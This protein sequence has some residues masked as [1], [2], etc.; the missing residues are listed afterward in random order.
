MM[1]T[2]NH[3]IAE[4]REHEELVNSWLAYY[5]IL[6]DSGNITG[7]TDIANPHLWAIDRL[8]DIGRL[9][10]EL[11]WQLILEILD[12]TVSDLQRVSLA[13][14]PLEDLLNRYGNDFIDRVEAVAGQNE[15]FREL[16]PGIWRNTI[17]AEVWDRIQR[18][19]S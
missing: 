4:F 3:D 18:L 19:C 7:Q 11:C 6:E 5:R 16:L 13:A 15:K 9:Q 12:R 10:P 14:G 8:D 2:D 1:Q 17:N